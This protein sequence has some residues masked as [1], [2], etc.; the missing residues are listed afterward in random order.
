MRNVPSF[1]IGAKLAMNVN[2]ETRNMIPDKFL[3]PSP[4]LYN[5]PTDNHYF[6]K[7]GPAL[8]SERKYFEQK[9]MPSIRARLP[10]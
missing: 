1:S 3:T 5:V 9:N 7:V 8:M 2:P 10:V 4:D 6:K